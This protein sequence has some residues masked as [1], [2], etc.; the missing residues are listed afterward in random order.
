M[1]LQQL[2]YIIAVDNHRHFAKAAQACFVTQP[3]LS[4]MLQ[5]LED[6]LG[7]LIFDRSKQP[8]VPTEIG[9]TIVEQARKILKEAAEMREIV[10]KQRQILKGELRLG[11]IP[12]L[13][14][15]LL[16]LFL[17]SF[18]EK[19]PDIHLIIAELTTD[20]I[21]QKLKKDQLDIGIMATPSGDGEL[22]ET[23]I[24]QEQFVVY[25]AKNE[26]ILEKRY[27]I[28]KDI[29]VNRLVLL[30]EGHCMRTQVVNL[31]ELRQ[32]TNQMSNIFYESGSIETL[33][34]LIEMHAG[35]TILP[36]LALRNLTKGQFKNIRFFQDP[37][38]VR[39]IS[40]VTYRA[41]VKKRLSEA[42]HN[43]IFMNLPIELQQAKNRAILSI[44]PT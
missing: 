25:A 13:A 3:T 21:I 10:E 24:F 6:E 39:E 9:R 4:M 42:L 37:A 5:K 38:P 22:F 15:Y 7:V 19:Y 29:D 1:T 12:T 40:L 26:E 35:V 20:T 8:V 14:P 23:P 41:F 33:K 16:P 34:N 32:T 31:C 27:L 28:A 30:E 18:S 36:E 43:E 2:E 11:I 17:K 44:L